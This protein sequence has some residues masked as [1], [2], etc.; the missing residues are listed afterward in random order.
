[1]RRVSYILP[2][3]LLAGCGGYTGKDVRIVIRPTRDLNDSRS[4]Y[5]LA[6]SVP[7]AVYPVE[8]YDDVATKAMAPDA[9]VQSTV[10]VL[11]GVAQEVKVPLP[12]EGRMAIYALFKQPEDH[13]WR[14]LLPA[15]LPERVELRL[16]R[17]WVCWTSN[18]VPKGAVGACGPAQLGVPVA[19]LPSTGPRL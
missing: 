17:S 16:G 15:G 9:S 1:M 3:A 13:S 14:F 5:L 6:R 11:P 4:I 2:A 19:E 10:V 18:N 12:A 8:S 7:D